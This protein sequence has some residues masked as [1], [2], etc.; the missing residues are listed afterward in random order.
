M[1]RVTRTYLIRALPRDP[2][3]HMIH[4][5][6]L[7]GQRLR[8]IL[9]VSHYFGI[10][11]RT[12]AQ[13]L[14]LVQ[15]IVNK[16]H[17]QEEYSDDEVLFSAE[18]QDIYGF[19]TFIKTTA[20]SV[21]N[22]TKAAAKSFAANAKTAANQASQRAA[23]VSKKVSEGVKK[24]T[25]D[26]KSAGD[27]LKSSNKKVTD[28]ITKTTNKVTNSTK[29]APKV[30]TPTAPKVTTPVTPNPN[31]PNTSNVGQAAAN[32]TPKTATPV[33][34]YAA[35]NNVPAAGTQYQYKPTT[36]AQPTQPAA[37]QPQS[38]TDKAKAAV[39]NGVTK[40][41][42]WINN[43]PKTTM[44]VGAAAAGLVAGGMLFGGRKAPAQ[45]QPAQPAQPIIIQR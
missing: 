39:T 14:D 5:D 35:N 27:K 22:S 24:T 45:Q 26:M 20:T 30:N 15:A 42:E 18:E 32:Q 33:G 34:P 41:G 2:N 31:A 28:S 44:G 23:E 17:I 43:N 7:D 16:V 8:L 9:A 19:G 40:A 36:P 37:T 3:L 11:H 21:S 1:I 10:P 12:A 29:S 25:S 4:P 38:T 13:L 6:S